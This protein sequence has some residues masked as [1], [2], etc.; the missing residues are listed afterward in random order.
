MCGPAAVAS[1]RTVVAHSPSAV[2][3]VAIVDLVDTTNYFHAQSEKT[4]SL[5]GVD[6]CTPTGHK[7]FAKQ[8]S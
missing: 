1:D 4:F 6:K 2:H 3:Q 8:N 7:Q 5:P